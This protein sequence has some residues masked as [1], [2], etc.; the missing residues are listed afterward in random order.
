VHS[1]RR[2]VELAE[3]AR[4]DGLRDGVT[5]P[6]LDSLGLFGDE[7][8]ERHHAPTGRIRSVAVVRKATFSLLVPKS[9]AMSAYT[10]TTMN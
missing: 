1:P 9:A 5:A 6:E 3:S 4:R 10:R 2:P 8:E 7:Y